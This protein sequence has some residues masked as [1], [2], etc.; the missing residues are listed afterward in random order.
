MRTGLRLLAPVGA[1]RQ[2]F[3]RKG[4]ALFSKAGGGSCLEIN[5]GADCGI[6]LGADCGIVDCGIVESC[7][8]DNGNLAMRGLARGDAQRCG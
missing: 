3:A 5:L 1:A 8:A 2:D 6:N 4:H 7:K